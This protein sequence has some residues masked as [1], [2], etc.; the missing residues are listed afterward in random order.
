MR[1]YTLADNS[2]LARR[3][4]LVNVSL[5][6]CLCSIS[7]I[8]FSIL[9]VH[10]D[11]YRSFWNCSCL[12]ASDSLYFVSSFLRSASSCYVNHWFSTNKTFWIDEQNNFPIFCRHSTTVMVTFE[13]SK[14]VSSHIMNHLCV[15][16]GHTSAQLSFTCNRASSESA[17]NILH[18]WLQGLR[19]VLGSIKC[20]GLVNVVHFRRWQLVKTLVIHSYQLVHRFIMFHRQY[21][22]CGQIMLL[23]SRGTLL[24]W[25][26]KR[27]G[28]LCLVLCIFSNYR[29]IN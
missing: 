22:P 5:S 7:K 27:L 20:S 26:I 25:G 6:S 1:S 17:H 8:Q 19:N 10:R 13:I 3:L 23:I 24:K 29:N 2:D 16:Y 11:P 21:R 4:S 15:H 14:I 18:C 9:V 28:I 12:N